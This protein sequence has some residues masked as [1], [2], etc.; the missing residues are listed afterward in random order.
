MCPPPKPKKPV[1]PPPPIE[2][3]E[4]ELGGNERAGATRQRKQRGRNQLRTGLGIAGALGGGGGL[5]IQ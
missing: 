2:A 5:S 4:I 1:G 3:P